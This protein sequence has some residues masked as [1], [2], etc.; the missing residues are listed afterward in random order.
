VDRAAHA[1]GEV[2][3]GDVLVHD[4]G[5]DAA[6]AVLSSALDCIEKD[7]AARRGSYAA[8]DLEHAMSREELFDT[9]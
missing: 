4:G 5:L 8:P 1:A 6:L 7:A 2:D 3:A 9:E